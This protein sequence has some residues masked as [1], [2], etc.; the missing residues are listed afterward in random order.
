MRIL[1][2]LTYIFITFSFGSLPDNVSESNSVGGLF[3]IGF[4]KE[5]PVIS[6]RFKS[7]YIYLGMIEL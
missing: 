7:Q 4:Y 2:L 6:K 1:N 3:C 5:E